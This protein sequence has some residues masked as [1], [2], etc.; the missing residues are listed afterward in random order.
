MSLLQTFQALVGVSTD[1]PASA[2]S[3]QQKRSKK[4]LTHMFSLGKQ[5]G[6]KASGFDHLLNLIN[7]G[8]FFQIRLAFKKIAR[9]ISSVNCLEDHNPL[10]E[11]CSCCCIR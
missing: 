4:L 10:R 6:L 8:N 9:F 3:P 1:T 11:V 7:S 5:I 2:M